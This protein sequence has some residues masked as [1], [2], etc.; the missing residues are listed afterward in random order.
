MNGGLVLV[1]IVRQQ[2]ERAVALLSLEAEKQWILPR[3]R[4]RLLEHLMSDY[5][6]IY[7]RPSQAV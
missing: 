6:V 5:I 2:P 3:L 4:S 7:N 1:H